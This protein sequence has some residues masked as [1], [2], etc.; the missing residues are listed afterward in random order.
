MV[1]RRLKLGNEVE[2]VE[3]DRYVW[4]QVRD[5]DTG[6]LL[7]H[8]KTKEPV[9]ELVQDGVHDVP[10]NIEVW[11]EEGDVI[12]VTNWA[13]VDSYVARGQIVLLPPD[14]R[15]HPSID[16]TVTEQK[17]KPRTPKAKPEGANDGNT[18]E[19]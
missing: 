14:V 8:R 18:A 17:R 3:E 1:L 15:D 11:A 7:F 12:D 5:E 2:Y 9:L 19:S 4:Q 16:N 13:G 6:E 10:H